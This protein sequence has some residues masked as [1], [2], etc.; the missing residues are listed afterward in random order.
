M[1]SEVVPFGSSNLGRGIG[2]GLGEEVEIYCSNDL[3]Y[4]L[5]LDY[6]K[7]T[8][9]YLYRPGINVTQDSR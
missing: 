9:Y 2:G 8:V 5:D 6:I 1:G 7:W 3:D 4:L